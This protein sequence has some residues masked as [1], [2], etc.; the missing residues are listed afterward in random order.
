M[1]QEI[2]CHSAPLTS[3]DPW[4]E[5]VLEVRFPGWTGLI[6]DPV[7]TV[8]EGILEAGMGMTLD[9]LHRS[10]TQIGQVAP[11]RT[12][13]TT[14]TTTLTVT[15]RRTILRTIPDLTTDLRITVVTTT[16][17]LGPTTRAPTIIRAHTTRK[18][19]ETNITEAIPVN[20]RLKVVITRI[21]TGTVIL[22][23]DMEIHQ[24]HQN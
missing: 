19:D 9:V 12:D 13:T 24:A 7:L 15:D 17:M 8:E 22:R 20:S 18:S 16:N 14:D 4:K 5:G 21:V 1:A 6:Q 10:V 23:R 11:L 3:K 2:T